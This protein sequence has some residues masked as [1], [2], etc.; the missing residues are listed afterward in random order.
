M[1]LSHALSQHSVTRKTN[2]LSRP[3]NAGSATR[4]G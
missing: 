3:A 4:A 1:S 2:F